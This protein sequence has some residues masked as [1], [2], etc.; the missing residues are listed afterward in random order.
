MSP[1]KYR[2]LKS[3]DSKI[4]AGNCRARWL[5]RGWLSRKRFLALIYI[6][7]YAKNHVTSDDI[8]WRID[9]P[10]AVKISLTI[11]TVLL[12]CARNLSNAHANIYKS[13]KIGTFGDGTLLT[14]LESHSSWKKKHVSQNYLIL[15]IFHS[16]NRRQFDRVWVRLILIDDWFIPN[17]SSSF[18]LL[19]L[20]R[21]RFEITRDRK[22]LEAK[23]KNVET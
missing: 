7:D 13:V 1:Q 18:R 19:I 11:H 22:N 10:S 2:F 9:G 23:I 3:A 12:G 5:R 15:V 14:H 17:H 8:M 6:F 16:D 21:D 20:E 4:T